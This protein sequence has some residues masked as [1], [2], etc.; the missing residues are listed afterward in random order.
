MERGETDFYQDPSD[1][2]PAL[3]AQLASLRAKP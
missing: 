1:F 3:K 2:D